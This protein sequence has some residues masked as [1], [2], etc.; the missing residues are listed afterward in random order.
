MH[1]LFILKRDRN[2]N[3]FSYSFQSVPWSSAWPSLNKDDIQTLKNGH[4]A[5]SHLHVPE[6]KETLQPYAT[7]LDPIPTRIILIN[8]NNLIK[9]KTWWLKNSITPPY[10]QTQCIELTNSKCSLKAIWIEEKEVFKVWNFK[11]FH[12]ILF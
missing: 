2:V 9:I 11:E 8:F 5:S 7:S 6:L 1:L 3:V 4:E 12:F 10:R